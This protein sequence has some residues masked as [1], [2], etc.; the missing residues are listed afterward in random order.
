MFTKVIDEIAPYCVAVSFGWCGEPLLHKKLCDMIAICKRRNLLTHMMTNGTLCNTSRCRE[1][2]EAGL[3]YIVFSFDGATKE[4]YE[5]IRVGANFQKTK[6]NI[7]H[8]V[9]ERN[10]MGRSLPFIDMQMVVVKQNSHEIVAY[11]A[12]CRQL[13]VDGAFLKSLYIDFRSKDADYIVKCQEKYFLSDEAGGRVPARY[14]ANPNGTIVPKNIE[15]CPQNRASQP[16]INVDGD[17]HLCCV[18][19]PG[20]SRFGNVSENTFIEIWKSYRNVRKM[21]GERKLAICVDCA[22]PYETT[23]RLF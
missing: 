13:G 23:H 16:V 5:G 7:R 19:I 10:K 3:D 21:A 1:L 8:L 20:E 12:M 22:M 11:E 9:E 17:V 2:I 15:N 6:N 4:I 18:D 14:D